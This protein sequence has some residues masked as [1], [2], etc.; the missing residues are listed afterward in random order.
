MPSTKF[1]RWLDLIAF[2]VSR[3][4]PV[5]VEDVMENVPAYAA[6]WVDGDA[7]S[8]DSVRRTFERD[9]DELRRLGSRSGPNATG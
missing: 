8:R 4:Y 7:R 6:N 3:R 9:K 1:Q 5:P 2:L